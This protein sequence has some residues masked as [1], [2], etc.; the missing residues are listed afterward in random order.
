MRPNIKE[1]PKGESL[2]GWSLDMY[3][4]MLEFGNGRAGRAMI[5]SCVEPIKA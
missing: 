4:S 3:H 2:F 1:V 5:D